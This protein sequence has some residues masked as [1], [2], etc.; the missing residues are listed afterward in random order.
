MIINFTKNTKSN[1]III[2]KEEQLVQFGK[3]EK[4]TSIQEN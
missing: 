1:Y 2:N 3:I 4:H